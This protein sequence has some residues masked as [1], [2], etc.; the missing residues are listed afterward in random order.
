MDEGALVV[1]REGDC[2]YQYLAHIQLEELT[3]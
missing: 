1:A 2:V 3:A